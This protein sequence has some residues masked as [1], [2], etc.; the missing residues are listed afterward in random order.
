MKL[1]VLRRLLPVLIFLPG[2]LLAQLPNTQ[3]YPEAALCTL[4][5][6]S[7]VPLIVSLVPLQSLATTDV[8]WSRGGKCGVGRTDGKACGAYLGIGV[9]NAS[10]GGPDNCGHCGPGM[11]ACEYGVDDGGLE[12]SVA[13]APRPETA[14][15]VAAIERRLDIIGK[16]GVPPS[17]LDYWRALTAVES[18]HLRAQLE[19]WVAP[20]E[21]EVGRD[22]LGTGSFEYWESGGRFHALASVPPAL[23]LSQVGEAAFDGRSYQIFM[24]VGGVLSINGPNQRMWPLPVRNPLFLPLKMLDPNSDECPACALRL[25]DLAGTSPRE[26]PSKA[27]DLQEVAVPAANLGDV[28]IGAYRIAEEPGARGGRRIFE[29]RSTKGETRRRVEMT[30]FNPVQ[31]APDLMFP[32]TIVEERFAEDGKL[33]QRVTYRIETIRA[34]ESIPDSIFRLDPPGVQRLWDE[35]HHMFV[36]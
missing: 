5:P 31:G 2:S 16:S 3:C 8:G 13:P 20:E 23:G 6:A 19:I 18:I 26:K 32:W 25:T 28:E 17:V 7:C 34:N 14:L 30:F 36:F 22:L 4:F 11:G 12:A 35:Q 33:L 1:I 15:E 29:A 9:C 27:G 10:T 24:P 21:T